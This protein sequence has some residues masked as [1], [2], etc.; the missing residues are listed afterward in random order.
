MSDITLVEK[1]R[2]Y[3]PPFFDYLVF[4]P[5]KVPTPT[6]INALDTAKMQAFQGVVG[7][8]S[9][10][11]RAGAMHLMS[12]SPGA[13]EVMDTVRFESTWSGTVLGL[14]VGVTI[15]GVGTHVIGKY[16]AGRR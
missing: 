2:T 15:G 9:P 13:K 12:E 8:L 6:G 1:V 10:T 11:E 14:L 3:V 16:L 5:P 4:V 7:S